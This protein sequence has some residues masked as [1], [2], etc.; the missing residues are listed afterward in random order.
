MTSGSPSSR[1]CN[2][3]GT[4]SAVRSTNRTTPLGELL[5]EV[6]LRLTKVSWR[7][8]HVKVSL[9]E[10]DLLRPRVVDLHT[11]CVCEMLHILY[12]CPVRHYPSRPSWT[13][14][15]NR[16]EHLDGTPPFFCSGSFA[17]RSRVSKSETRCACPL[18]SLSVC[19]LVKVH[20]IPLVLQLRLMCT[21]RKFA[22]SQSS[23]T[24][25]RSL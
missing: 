2:I 19:V 12:F 20:C 5:S 4:A 13:K 3:Q 24:D 16:N 14:L 9:C 6:P 1:R 21:R 10:E 22:R 7:H 8:S 17:L 25:H 11:V 15:D 18:Y 23:A